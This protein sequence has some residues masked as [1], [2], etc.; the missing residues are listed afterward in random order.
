MATSARR[1]LPSR[2]GWPS[3]M[4]CARTAAWERNVCSFVSGVVRWSC[5]RAFQ[6]RAGAE[7]DGG[8]SGRAADDRGVQLEGVLEREIDQ[9]ELVLSHA[10]V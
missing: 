5:E 2:N 6:R 3:A 9:P 8:V 7:G 4:P 1:L 10:S